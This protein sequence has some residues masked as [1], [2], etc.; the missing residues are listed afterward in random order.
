[1]IENAIVITGRAQ[2]TVA[3]AAQSPKLPAGIYDVWGT[4]DMYVK[5]SKT[6]ASD[7]TSGTGYLIRSGQTVPLKLAAG[8]CIGVTGATLSYHQVG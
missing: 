1:M 2:G 5:V 3:S 4:A 7:V 8:E 6:T